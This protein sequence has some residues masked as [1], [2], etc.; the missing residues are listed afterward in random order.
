MTVRYTEAEAYAIQARN[1]IKTLANTPYPQRESMLQ[2]LIITWCA[3]Q[4]PRWKCIHARTDKRS[5]LDAGTPDFVIFG[6]NKKCL[7]IECKTLTGKISTEQGG[8]IA[9][10][11]MIQWPVLIV[12]SYEE[13][14]EI[15]KI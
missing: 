13:F 1:R 11:A 4:W 10:M 3:S 6:P 12:R 15:V 5:T 2:R 8:W 7:I 14:L 9:E